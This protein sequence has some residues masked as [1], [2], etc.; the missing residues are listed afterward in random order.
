MFADPW[1]HSTERT[2]GACMKIETGSPWLAMDRSVGGLKRTGT[3]IAKAASDV[4]DST[5]DILNGRLEMPQDHVQL[6]GPVDLDEALMDLKFNQHGYT[7]NLRAVKV[8]DEAI[9][10]LLDM[11]SPHDLGSRR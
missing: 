1:V 3:G 9:A 4:V 7:A 6:S 5:M 11:V 10:S 8:S 2:Q